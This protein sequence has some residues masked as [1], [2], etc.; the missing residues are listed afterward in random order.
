MMKVW[1]IGETG[2]TITGKTIFSTANK[3]R[4]LH[5]FALND[6]AEKQSKNSES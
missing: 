4:T 1:N 2:K 6:F 5:D 3:K